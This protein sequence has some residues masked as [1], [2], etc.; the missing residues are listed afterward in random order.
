[1]PT[2][3]SGWAAGIDAKELIQRVDGLLR[4][5]R[6]AEAVTQCAALLAAFPA[7]A[8]GPM[9]MARA[10]QMQGDFPGMLAAA[11]EAR[12]LDPTSEL[13]TFIEIEA[14]LHAGEVAAARERLCE[15]EAA[16]GQSPASLRKC[17]EFH[18]HLGQ[19]QDAARAARALV[20]VRPNDTEARYALASALIAVGPLNEAEALLDDLIRRAPADGDAY[21]NRATL[22]RQTPD[23]NH[24]E[25]LRQA[26]A[27]AGDSL[28]RVPL[29]FALAK[30]LEDLGE[31]EASFHHTAAGAKIRRGLLGYR[32]ESDEQTIERIMRTFDVRWA[33]HST[34]GYEPARPIFVVGMPRSGTTLVER[35][36][37]RHSEVASV[38]ET[39]DLALAVMRAAGPSPDKLQLVERSATADAAALGGSYWNAI[40][41]YGHAEAV[42]IDKTPLNFLY[43]GLIRRALSQARIIHVRRHPMA[44]GYA[45]YRTLFRMGYPFS[46]D[47]TD[48]ARYIVA[49]QR[50]MN[51]WQEAF[52]GQFLD[53]DYEALVDDQEGITRRLLAFCGLP[54]EEACLSFHEET[55]PT[56]TASA[57]QVRQPMYRHARDQWRHYERQLQPLAQLF[58]QAGIASR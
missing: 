24:I 22:R 40:R 25:Q 33:R 10:R 54:W 41:G 20:S 2:H 18:T 26:L 12:R 29:N 55:R 57:A 21:Y 44:S 46:Y 4:Q 52:P 50:L 23:R 49:Y 53:I 7:R 47:L 56:A 17:V 15:I 36:L 1:M 9:L 14:L 58:E 48:L 34:P 38:G 35:I 19:H 32:I 13:A 31:Y 43:L 37:G 30:E 11:R 28:A 8:E 5:R 39:N 42:I 45:M 51:H 27:A 3:G 16:T 6:I